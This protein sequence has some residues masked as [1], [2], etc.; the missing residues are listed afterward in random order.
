VV[1]EFPVKPSLNCYLHYKQPKL[2]LTEDSR[3]TDS[4]FTTFQCGREH[5]VHHAYSCRN[6][7]IST[8]RVAPLY[9]CL[10]LKEN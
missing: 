7:N 6:N 10:G 9:P 4:G 8:D 2:G 5:V 3:T 1:L